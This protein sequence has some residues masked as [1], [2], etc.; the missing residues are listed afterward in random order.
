MSERKTLTPEQAAELRFLR[1]R[2]DRLQDEQLSVC[3]EMDI[4]QR[5]FHARQ[6]LKDYVENL[7]KQGHQI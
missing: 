6:E 2:V 3:K 5:I 4:A 7:R 1:K